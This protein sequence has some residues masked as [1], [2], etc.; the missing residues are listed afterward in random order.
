MARRVPLRSDILDVIAVTLD[1]R[2]PFIRPSPPLWRRLS[3]R[4][5]GRGD[6]E[7]PVGCMGGIGRGSGERIPVGHFATGI[8]LRLGG[9]VNH[10][11]FSRQAIGIKC[12]PVWT[13]G[14]TPFLGWL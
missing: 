9:I 13:T 11:N 6:S 7:M 12:V 5:I 4:A 1:N 10:D 3:S 8:S 2:V 14:P